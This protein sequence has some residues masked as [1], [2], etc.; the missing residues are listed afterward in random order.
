MDILA[1]AYITYNYFIHISYEIG[2]TQYLLF[3]F[4]AITLRGVL[5]GL[6]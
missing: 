4:V 6:N 3:F 1:H 2:V 5:Y